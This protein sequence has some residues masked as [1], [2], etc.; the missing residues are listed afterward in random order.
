MRPACPT[1]IYSCEFLNF[2]ISRTRLDLAG[3]TAINEI[4]G[5]DD[6]DLDEY[7][8]E[9]SEKHDLM[10]E[11]I[12]IRLRLTTLKYQKMEDLVKAIGLPKEKLCTHC[13]DKSSYT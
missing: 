8:D 13:W 6:V 2:S 9:N 5:R 1:L 10:V 7:M 11:K 3:R 12:R 4:E